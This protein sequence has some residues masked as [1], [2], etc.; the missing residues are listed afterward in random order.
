MKNNNMG[1]KELKNENEKMKKCKAKK[2]NVKCA[3]QQAA[4]EY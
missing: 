1:S 2:W 4:A 3:Y